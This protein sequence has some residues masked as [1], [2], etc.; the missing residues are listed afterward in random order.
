MCPS[1]GVPSARLKRMDHYVSLFFIPLIPVKRGER[2]LECDRCGRI[3]DEA[4]RSEAAEYEAEP[5]KSC[6]RCGHQ[7]TPGFR[8]CPHCGHKLS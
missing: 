3:F 7:I 4:G 1:C 5:S 8:F 6:P 2:F